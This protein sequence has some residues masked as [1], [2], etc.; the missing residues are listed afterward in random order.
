MY[1]EWTWCGGVKPKI[2]KSKNLS[3][4]Q[5]LGLGKSQRQKIYLQPYGHV[6]NNII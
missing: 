3:F 1:L 5:N 4:V 2:L 6:G